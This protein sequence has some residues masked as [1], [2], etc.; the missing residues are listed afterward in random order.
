MKRLSLSSFAD[1]SLTF[2]AGFLVSLWTNVISDDVRTKLRAINTSDTVLLVLALLVLI[3][4]I[5]L[6]R[7]ARDFHTERTFAKGLLEG[8]ARALTVGRSTTGLKVRGHLHKYDSRSSELRPFVM[9]SEPRENDS[10]V[11]FNVNDC[12]N[13]EVKIVEAWRDKKSVAAEP[14]ASRPNAYPPGMKERI[15]PE[16][17]SVLAVPV[18]KTEGVP[19]DMPIGVLSFDTNQ[20]LRTLGLDSKEARL[21]VQRVAES[22]AKLID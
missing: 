4:A 3:C 19:L 5:W 16:L 11:V 10:F 8:V 18:M 14:N 2:F 22:C 7:R 9:W 21:L 1:A 13:T 12:A 15:W 20:S 6:R 17:R